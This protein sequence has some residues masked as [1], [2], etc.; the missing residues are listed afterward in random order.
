MNKKRILTGDRPTGRLQIG[1]YIGS[2][3]KRVELQERG[4]NDP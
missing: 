1:L 2:L 3:K 4:E